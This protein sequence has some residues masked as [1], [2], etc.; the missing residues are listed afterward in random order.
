MK[1][2]ILAAGYATRLHPLTENTPKHLLEIG[3]KPIL[4]H[5]L[6]KLEETD[7]IKEIII[8]TNHRF[9]HKF[10]AWLLKNNYE[11][12]KLIN[13]GTFTN[14][15]RLGAIGDLNFVLKEEDINEDLIVIAGDN[16]FGFSMRNFINLSNE[17]ESSLVAFYDLKDID[18]VRRKFGV[19]MLEGT[20]VVEFE[21]KPWNPK[22]S[23][24]ATACYLFKKD[25]LRLVESLLKQGK[26]DAPGDMIKWLVQR[27][28]VHGY[29]FNEHWFDVGS[30][31][32]LEEA[33]KVYG[34]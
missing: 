17:T 23:L 14:N 28:K 6:D 32:S 25:D 18:K 3:G 5:V 29:V 24:A 10:R 8:V 4:Q 27:S 12:I 26:G 34:E 2:L 1:A 15:D 30:F 13:D 9:Y 7:D 20:R 33:K 22:S 31:E 21:E 11:N 19:G 16:L